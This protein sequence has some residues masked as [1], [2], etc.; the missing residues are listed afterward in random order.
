MAQQPALSS[1]LA[2]DPDFVPLQVQAYRAALANTPREG[3]LPIQISPT[4]V[5]LPVGSGLSMTFYVLESPIMAPDLAAAYPGI[6]TYV[7]RSVNDQTIS[8]RMMVSDYGIHATVLMPHGILTIHPEHM[9]F[10]SNHEVA[11]SWDKPDSQSP[12][13]PGCNE[14]GEVDMDK[15]KEVPQGMGR[16]IN[17][18]STIRNYRIAIVTTGEFHDANGGTVASATATVVATMNGIQAIYN[19]E[20]AVNFTVLTPFI[21]TDFASDPFNPGL[22]RPEEAANAV[23]ANFNINDYDIGHVFHDQDQPPAEL[24]GGGVAGLGVVCDNSAFFGTGPNKAA[25]WS[26]SF[27]NVSDSWIDLASHELGHMFNAPHTFNGTGGSCTANISSTTSYEI[28]SGNSIMS[29]NGI[30]GAGQNIPNGGTA[31]HYFHANSLQRMFDYMNAFGTCAATS[32]NANTPPVVD[33]N[34][35]GGSHSIPKSTPFRL[36]G[37]ATD[38]DNDPLLYSWE[39]YNED[40]AGTPTQGFI[41]ATA[42]ASALAPLFRSYP[43]NGSPTRYFPA[44]NLILDNDYSSSFEPLPSVPRTL[45]FRLNVRDWA[46]P[47]GGIDGDSLDV[48]VTN[49]GPLSV[50]SP[51]G[52][53]NLM[54]GNSVSVTWS[55]NGTNT[56]SANVNIRL[57][58]DGGYTYPYV[59]AANTPNDGSQSVTIP[60]GVPDVSTARMMVESAD[61]ECVV[62]FDLS[63]DNFDV[64]SDCSART[65]QICDIEQVVAPEGDPALDINPVTIYGSPNATFTLTP[66][67]SSSSGLN[68]TP[69]AP[70]PGTCY[71][72]NFTYGFQSL[73]FVV[74][75]TGDYT[76]SGWSGFNIVSLYTS[77]FSS[78]SPCTNYLGSN[79]YDVDGIPFGPTQSAGSLTMTLTECT[80]YVV[81]L[82]GTSAQTISV[83]GPAGSTFY[84]INNDPL[85]ANYT[86]TYLA[87]NTATNDV[88]LV[89]ASADFTSLNAGSYLMYGAHYYSG[90]GPTPPVVTP[91]SWVN[92]SIEEI[93]ASGDCVVFS[94]NSKPVIV[95][96]VVSICINEVDSDTPGTDAAEF[97]ELYDGG[98][99][100]T[101]LDGFALVFFNGGDDK[102]YYA[103]D[104]DTYTTDANGFFI[105]GNAGVPGVDIVFAGNTLQNGADAVAVY[106]ANATD[107]PNGTSVT[108]TN[109]VDAIVY[110][111]DDADDTGLLTGLGQ[112]TQYNENQNGDKDNQ[113]ISRVPDCGASVLTQLATPNVTNQP[114]A[115]ISIAATDASKNEGNAGTTNFIF[116]A[117]RT[118]YLRHLLCGLGCDRFRCRPRR[119]R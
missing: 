98:V 32:A 109:L 102:S 13:F 110:D 19:K 9:D 60:D 94:G 106:E 108:T 118:G 52:G 4:K 46:T 30:C 113:S 2:V 85:P 3:S 99:G 59:L 62:F 91:A 5:D 95:Q 86:Q 66:S 20:L 105:V 41:G 72:A 6:R 117:T 104:L 100:N 61:N 89:S 35:C 53:E 114:P 22:D 54:A 18:G 75:Q 119:Y 24:P 8:G 26:G 12:V 31:D 49:D 58:I 107:F 28:A 103:V 42:G 47:A 88:A 21:Y 34:P 23:D 101:P 79:A 77:S 97:V 64:N 84:Q 71:S 37:A 27:D 116:T 80:T 38:D 112:S 56:L 17:N 50:T 70:G 87:V 81:V 48:V 76:F 93:L 51:N 11:A 65:N 68:L 69:A 45:K 67:G 36:T 57:S 115:V 16:S 33:I 14:N 73:T 82:W 55:V 74:D 25:G 15:P 43:P 92:Q 83:N 1:S 39:Q 7:I 78:G 29:Y 96:S 10:T 44:L 63:D 90:G 40:G 111:T